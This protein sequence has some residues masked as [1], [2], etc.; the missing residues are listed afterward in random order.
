LNTPETPSQIDFASFAASSPS[1][2]IATVIA[3]VRVLPPILP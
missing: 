2:I 1:S 3:I